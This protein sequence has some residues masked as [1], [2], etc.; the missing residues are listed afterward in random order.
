MDFRSGVSGDFL[1]GVLGVAGGS[2][3]ETMNSFRTFLAPLLV[4]LVLG[5]AAAAPAT[6]PAGVDDEKVVRALVL[7]MVNALARGDEEKARALYHGGDAD[8]LR[9]VEAIAR[10]V[11]L[12][13]R[14]VDEAAHRFGKEEARETLKPP[15]IV[16]FARRAEEVGV[17]K[18]EGD[19]AGFDRP[20]FQ[21]PFRL[22]R[23][24]GTWKLVAIP[25]TFVQRLEEIETDVVAF[26]QVLA[27]VKEGKY[28]DLIAVRDAVRDRPWELKHGQPATRPSEEA[29]TQPVEPAT[30]PASEQ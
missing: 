4:L 13:A 12:H 28:E 23:D 30:R 27:E 14:I 1:P 9:T 7:E 19:E 15:G 22:F 21:D 11:D 8:T 3:D 24:E 20:R 16:S 25:R 6:R 18:I 26:E 5:C 29:A 17:V 2:Y 10:V